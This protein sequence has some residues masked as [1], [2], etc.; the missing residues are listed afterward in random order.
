MSLEREIPR[1]GTGYTV[2]TWLWKYFLFSKAVTLLFLRQLMT[3]KDL[4]L[5]WL[6]EGAVNDIWPSLS[7]WSG[8][9]LI[10]SPLLLCSFPHFVN[11]SPCLG[12]KSTSGNFE[13]ES[14]CYS[15][16]HVQLSVTPWTVAWQAP[17]SM[18]FSRQEYWSG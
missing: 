11:F 2:P 13:S 8:F 14:K 1:K 5:W 18:E 10:S 6:Y 17:L 3:V 12:L 4:R 7:Y 16:S 15:L 9:V